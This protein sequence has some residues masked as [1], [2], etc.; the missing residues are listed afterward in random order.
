ML[1]TSPSMGAVLPRPSPH[2]G[3][4]ADPP[5]W[6]VP[7][8][9]EV[10][11][12]VSP[13]LEGGRL[14]DVTGCPKCVRDPH[15]HKKFIYASDFSVSHIRSY[16]P[17]ACERMTTAEVE[18][19]VACIRALAHHVVRLSVPY[20]SPHRPEIDAHGNKYMWADQRGKYVFAAGSGFVTGIHGPYFD[21]D[22]NGDSCS[23]GGMK[24]KMVYNV[25]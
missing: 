22:D 15:H 11:H 17:A 23:C 20:V 14:D 24:E 9:R 2:P 4:P 5:S 25:N 12:G 3:S 16:F 18:E 10:A 19:A 13:G 8:R 6:D 7:H 21:R 1:S